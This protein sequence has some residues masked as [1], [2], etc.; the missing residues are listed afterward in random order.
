MISLFFPQ[1]KIIYLFQIIY[2]I[3]NLKEIGGK[4]ID[5][6]MTQDK[7][8]NSILKKKNQTLTIK[9]LPPRVVDTSTTGPGMDQLSG[10]Q[11]GREEAKAAV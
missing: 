4:E 9:I 8:P 5:C 10:G 7:K 2:L 3:Q 1:N 11:A 6:Y